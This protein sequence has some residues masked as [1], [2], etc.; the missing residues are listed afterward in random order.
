MHNLRYLLLH[1]VQPGTNGH[2]LDVPWSVDS[3]QV[4][5]RLPESLVESSLQFLQ[6]N[7]MSCYFFN[8]ASLSTTSSQAPT[9]I[10]TIM[11]KCPWLYCSMTSRTSYGFLACWNFLLATKYLI[12]LIARMAFLCASVSLEDGK[13]MQWLKTGFKP[14]LLLEKSPRIDSIGT[15][16][17]LLI[18]LLSFIIRTGLLSWGTAG[19]G[20]VTVMSCHVMWRNV[21]LW[22]YCGD[23]N[24]WNALAKWN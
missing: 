9:F 7:T 16:K 10:L 8:G 23:Q 21:N 1:S 12:F 14:M 20:L 5:A 22:S 3:C 15:L 19:H 2:R 11:F 6:V 4:A 24:W 17:Q 13:Q 18:P